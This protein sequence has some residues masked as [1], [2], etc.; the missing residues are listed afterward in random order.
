MLVSQSHQGGLHLVWLRDSRSLVK[1]KE[2]DKQKKEENRLLGA[3]YGSAFWTYFT[4]FPAIAV[5]SIN[6]PH[7]PALTLNLFLRAIQM[8]PHL[9][10]QYQVLGE[11]RPT[12]STNWIHEIKLHIDIFFSS[13]NSVFLNGIRNGVEVVSFDFCLRGRQFALNFCICVEL[14]CWGSGG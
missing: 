3:Q 4:P 11:L 6:D 2:E 9:H 7:L 5:P 13:W 1:V 12:K 10:I 8:L 14:A